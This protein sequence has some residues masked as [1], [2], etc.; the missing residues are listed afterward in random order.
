MKYFTVGVS[1]VDDKFMEIK[2]V[3][4]NDLTKILTNSQGMITK[5]AKNVKG[6]GLRVVYKKYQSML[7]TYD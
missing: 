5:L 3:I 1:K 2:K 7:K 6:K 4:F